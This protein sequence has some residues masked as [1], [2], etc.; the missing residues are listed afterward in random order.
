MS[1]IRATCGY[2][3]CGVSETPGGRDFLL[4]VSIPWLRS[5]L[6]DRDVLR[7]EWS[8]IQF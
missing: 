1:T 7:L 4:L 3:Y 5:I 2:W 8:C 6:M